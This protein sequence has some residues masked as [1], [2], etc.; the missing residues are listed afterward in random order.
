MAGVVRQLI[1]LESLS[2]YIERNVPEI[3]LPIQIKQFGFGQSNPTYDLM[4]DNGRHYVLRK[5]PPGK[6]LSK[7]AHQ[8][9][10]EYRIIHALEVTDVPVPKAYC[11][12]D[13]P[14]V[15]GTPFYIMEFLDGRIFENASLPGLSADERREMWHDAIRTLAKLHR[16]SPAAVGLSTFG[17]PSGFYNRQLK[18]LGTISGS[19]AQ[20]IDVESHKAVGKIPHFDDMVNFFSDPNK[21][22]KERATLIHGDYKIDNLVYHKTEPRIIGILDWEMSTIGHPLSDLSNLLSPFTFALQPPTQALYSR[23]NNAFFPSAATPG[24]PSRSQCIEW[25]AEVAGWDPS[26]ETGWG[27]AFGVFR[28]SVIMQGIAARYALRQASSARAKE[29]AV[30]M[31]PFGEFAWGLVA[32]LEYQ[33]ARNPSKL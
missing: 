2:S 19:Q 8:V 13:D 15:I 29:Y 22:P 11:L 16:L 30:Q 33:A 7:T 3:R 18:T 4:A 23:I 21:Q 1:D 26:S 14:S 32:E 20:A 17:K 28:N 24:L 9:E 31:K 12:C 5:K 6:L 10:R 25:Y 27:D